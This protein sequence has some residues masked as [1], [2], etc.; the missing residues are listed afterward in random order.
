MV[1][2][3]W[4]AAAR[5]PPYSV[6][7][8]ASPLP[9]ELGVSE[10]LA[11]CSSAAGLG[12]PAAARAL[13]AAGEA[14][15]PSA[16][17]GI[18]RGRRGRARHAAAGTRDH[19]STATTT[20][21]ASARRRSSCGPA[22]RSAPTSTGTCPSRPTTATAS[23]RATVER[24]AARGTRLLLTADCAI[25]AVDEVAAARAA[26]IDVVVTDHHQPR[27]DGALPDAPIVHPAL[28]GYPCADLCATGVAY[29]LARGAAR[30][31]AGRDPAERRRR[32]RPR[33]ARDGRRLR[34]AASARTAASCAPGC[35]ALAGT[36]RPGLRALMRVARSTRARST[37]ATLGFR[38][39]PRINAAGRLHRADAGLELLLTER[40]RRAPTQIAARARRRRT[41][42]AAT[43]RRAS[44]SRPRRRSREAG[45]APA[46]VLAGEGWHPGVIGIVASRIAERHHR[47][48]R[49]DRARRRRGHGLGP[50]DPGL[51][52][53]RRARR[54]RRPPRSA[55]AATARR[56]AA[57]RRATRRR[58]SAPRSRRTRARC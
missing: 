6:R 56:P 36:A 55:T 33:R 14:H 50:L 1:R 28:C 27:A 5:I 20:S 44:C 16:F 41:P 46:Y 12:D 13:L 11:R 17:A 15:D 25:T 38:L 57:D 49:D 4:P 47:P 31:G 32:P 39:A 2:R 52:P 51:R 21:T 54:L 34:A 58:R 10:P 30:G 35:E 24:L 22:R 18:E 7:R 23:R 19:A 53:A 48:V 9:R 29:K 43:P 42:S 3:E 37:R 45:D 26:G 8:R 40:R